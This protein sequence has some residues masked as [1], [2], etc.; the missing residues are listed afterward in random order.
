[1]AVAPSQSAAAG[2]TPRD[3]FVTEGAL[4]FKVDR[5]APCSLF[6]DARRGASHRTTTGLR[7]TILA[8]MALT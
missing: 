6:A 8:H 1:M 5:Q 4:V 2:F 3:V 7:S